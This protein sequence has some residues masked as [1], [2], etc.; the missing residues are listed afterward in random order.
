MDKQLGEN[1]E[2]RELE[3]SIE[4]KIEKLFVK[5]NIKSYFKENEGWM[6]A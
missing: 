3:E 4:K 6:E 1:K 2:R 5:K